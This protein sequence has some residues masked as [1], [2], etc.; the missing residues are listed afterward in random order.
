MRRATL[1]VL[2]LGCLAL[3]LGTVLGPN[4]VPQVLTTTVSAEPFPCTG[5]CALEP[6]QKDKKNHHAFC[7]FDQSGA[8]VICPDDT[9]IVDPHLSDHTDRTDGTNDFCINSLEDLAACEKGEQP[10]PK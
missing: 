1:A 10:P 4:V 5:S 2:V 7:H 9:A 6:G 8:H 3:G